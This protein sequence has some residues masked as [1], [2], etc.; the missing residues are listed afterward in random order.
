MSELTERLGDPAYRAEVTA[1]IIFESRHLLSTLHTTR[2]DVYFDQED[3]ISEKKVFEA[4]SYAFRDL[5]RINNDQSFEVSLAKYSAY[6]AFWFAKMKPV[7]AVYVRPASNNDT[8]EHAAQ[9]IEVTDINE[10]MAVSLMMRVLWRTAESSPALSP[11]VWINCPNQK[12]KE[13]TLSS[14]N[15]RGACFVLKSTDHLKSDDRKFEKYIVYCLRFRP[16]APYFLVNILDQFLFSSC[17][18][19]SP[20]LEKLLSDE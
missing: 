4:V 11:E 12:C 17:A 19:S 5:D 20:T 13:A 14:R 1:K 7:R 9:D 18:S 8:D 6:I 2:G 16:V 15:S 10:R 3:V